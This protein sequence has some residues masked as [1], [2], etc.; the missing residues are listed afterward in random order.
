MAAEDAISVVSVK[1]GPAGLVVVRV[2]LSDGKVRQMIMGKQTL[3]VAEVEW[4]AQAL[5]ALSLLG[6]I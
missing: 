4:S 5:E 6:Q 3:G 1:A 2:R